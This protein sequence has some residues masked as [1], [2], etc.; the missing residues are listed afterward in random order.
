[1][2]H[3]P[4]TS[5]SF[6]PPVGSCC[7]CFHIFWHEGLLWHWN[8][9][10]PVLTRNNWHT[11]YLSGLLLCGLLSLKLWLPSLLLSL[12]CVLTQ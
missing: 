10:N 6:L 4:G 12:T 7:A 8:D 5:S 11:T 1:M 2:I 9:I 3:S